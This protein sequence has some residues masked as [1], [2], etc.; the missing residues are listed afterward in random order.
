MARALTEALAERCSLGT[1]AR[2]AIHTCLGELCQNV[3]NHAMT[4]LGGIALAQGY[5][6]ANRSEVA[7]V[8]VGIGIR[9]SL[10]AYEKYARITDDAEA[11]GKALELG[12][13][14]KLE[15]RGRG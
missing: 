7:I 5:P 10:N 2:F 13:T 9:A 12:T 1:T 15:A 6:A 11:I 4:E 8:D 3:P 14:S